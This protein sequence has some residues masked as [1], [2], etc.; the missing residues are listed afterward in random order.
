MTDCNANP[1]VFSSL[2]RKQ[3]VADFDGGSITSD[4]G[5]LLLREVDRHLGLIDRLDAVI[6]DPRDPARIIHGQRHMLAQRIFAI[7]LGYEDVNDH[8][9]LRDDPLMQAV[10]GRGIDAGQ[11]LASPT[12]L[13]RLENRTGEGTAAD[14]KMLFDMS[15]VLVEVFIASHKEPPTEIVLDF[16]ATDDP[17]HGKQVNRFFHG[18]YDHHCFLPLYVFC[19]DHLLVA[20]LRPSNIDGAKH[21]RAILKL[22]VRRIRQAWPAVRIIVRGDSGFCRWRLMRWCDRNGV[23]Y[24]LGLAKNPSL[25]RL[26][27]AAML[28]GRLTFEESGHKARV[29]DEFTYAAATWGRERR[30][31]LRY[32]H[33][34]QGPNPRY[35]VTSLAKDEHE[36]QALYEQTY[37]ARGE[38]ENRIKEQQL[39]LF[40][41]RTSCHEFLPNQF[42]VL[43]S[44][45]AYVLF[46]HLRRVGLRGTELQEAQVGTLRLKLMK[47]GARVVQ[48]VR[49]VVLHLSS[50]F[51]LRELFTQLARKLADLPVLTYPPVVLPS[52]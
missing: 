18:Y 31:I 1:I 36:G 47:I 44:A 35:V 29:F 39:D 20:Y 27:E 50:G 25:Q 33:D 12:T 52:G 34:A 11:S 13:G 3:V 8:F 42:R 45:A 2:G 17:V 37:C 46:D 30:V 38:C 7:A 48:S 6:P 4:G 16:D 32:E 41:G 19:G 9:T 21:S 15:A 10:S 5:A 43:L 24:L 26:S 40:A 49:R 28:R 22:L 14:R 51:P 23:D